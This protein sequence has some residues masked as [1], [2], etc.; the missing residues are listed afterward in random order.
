M[1]SD[2]G[3]DFFADAIFGMTPEAWAQAAAAPSEEDGT[4]MHFFPSSMVQQSESLQFTDFDSTY[5]TEWNTNLQ[6]MMPAATNDMGETYLAL[7]DTSGISMTYGA[8]TH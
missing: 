3:P 1:E 4:G 6:P 8:S 5:S 7:G 2:S